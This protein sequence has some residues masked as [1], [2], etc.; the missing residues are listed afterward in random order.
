[1]ALHKNFSKSPRK[2]LDR[3]IRWFSDEGACLLT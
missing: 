3:K 2:I 1:M